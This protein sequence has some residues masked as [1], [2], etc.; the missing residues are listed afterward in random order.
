[1]LKEDRRQ[2]TEGRRQKT[3]N[4]KCIKKLIGR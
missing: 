3:E 1:M 4:K 2:K